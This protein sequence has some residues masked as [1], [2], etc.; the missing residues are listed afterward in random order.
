MIYPPEVLVLIE[1]VLFESRTYRGMSK[2]CY[3]GGK[4]NG[5]FWPNPDAQV[6]FGY[7]KH[8][9]GPCLTNNFRYLQQ[10]LKKK[11]MSLANKMLKTSICIPAMILEYLRY[12][13]YQ[14]I[15]YKTLK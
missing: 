14:I 12:T 2:L 15:G 9:K 4:V 8:T 7:K 11:N 3:L 13:S 1:I 5:I 6:T 10:V